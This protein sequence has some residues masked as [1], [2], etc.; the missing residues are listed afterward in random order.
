MYLL[1]RPIVLFLFSFSLLFAIGSLLPQSTPLLLGFFALIVVIIVLIR[2]MF[3][4]KKQSRQQELQQQQTYQDA[5]TQVQNEAIEAE[6]AKDTF[7]ANISHETRTPMNA[8]IGLSH[9]LLQSDLDH[10]QKTNISKIK[11]SAEHLLAITNDILD[12]SKIEAGKLDINNINFEYHLLF[13]D[14]ADMMGIQAV[15]KKLDLIFD[16]SPDVPDSLIGDPLR[17]SQVLINLINNAIKFTDKG[18]IILHVSVASHQDNIYE[19]R[20]E[21]YTPRSWMYFHQRCF[22]LDT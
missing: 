20:F 7:L 5:I 22:R 3:V 8:I 10:V 12:F 2:L 21:D 16:I 19:I 6:R 17:I 14:L 9:I 1:D 18:E 11:R 4:M 15:E 13:N